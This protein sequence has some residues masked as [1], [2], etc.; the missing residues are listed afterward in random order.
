VTKTI[1]SSFFRERC[2]VEYLAK[3][4]GWPDWDNFNHFAIDYL[5]QFFGKLLLKLDFLATFS[6][7]KVLY[8]FWRKMGWAFFSQ[9]HLGPM[10]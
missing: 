1:L 7:V 10:L 2:L 3:C 8:L 5:V 4:P 6:T 9:T